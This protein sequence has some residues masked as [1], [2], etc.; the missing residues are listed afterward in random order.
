MNNYVKMRLRSGRLVY[1]HR[2]LMERKL[3]RPLRVNEVVDHINGNKSDNRLSNLCVRDLSKHTRMHYKK[4]DYHK[5]TKKEA[6]KGAKVTNK[7]LYGK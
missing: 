7:L 1:V 4:G 5:L 2:Y 3:G 6:R